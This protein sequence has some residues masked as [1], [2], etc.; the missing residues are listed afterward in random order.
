MHTDGETE[1]K[2]KSRDGK[3]S[4][5]YLADEAEDPEGLL[6]PTHALHPTPGPS[7]KS[8]TLLTF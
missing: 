3:Y 6:P 1:V 8:V 4:V 5:S 7:S 2:R